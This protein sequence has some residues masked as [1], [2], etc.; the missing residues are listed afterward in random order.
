MAR[1][2]LYNSPEEAVKAASASISFDAQRHA[3]EPA[4]TK[5]MLTCNPGSED[6][7]RDQLDEILKGMESEWP[8]A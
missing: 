1:P 6:A 8:G 3:I 4:D 5:D 7:A 2:V